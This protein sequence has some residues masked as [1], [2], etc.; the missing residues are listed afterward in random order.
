MASGAQPKRGYAERI[1]ED[2][3]D[4]EKRIY[5][6]ATALQRDNALWYSFKAGSILLPRPNGGAMIT[7]PLYMQDIPSKTDYGNFDREM[8]CINKYGQFVY[9]FERN[10]YTKDSGNGK[11]VYRKDLYKSADNFACLNPNEFFTH[12][13]L[14]LFRPN[15]LPRVCLNVVKLLNDITLYQT[16]KQNI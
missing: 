1:A 12:N 13:V 11:I 3:K 16:N 2:M 6:I 10:I 7:L 8:V 15:T 14:E 5:M 9:G 4:T